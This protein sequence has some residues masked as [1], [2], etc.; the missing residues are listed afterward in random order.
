MNL[1]EHFF[2]L[3]KEMVPP[4]PDDYKRFK[5]F[6]QKLNVFLFENKSAYYMKD[7]YKKQVILS[8][9]LLRIFG[10]SAETPLCEK[11]AEMEKLIPRYEL[12]LLF[13]LHTKWFEFISALTADECLNS[14]F[15]YEFMIERKQG[16][17]VVINH[18]LRPLFL[19]SGGDIWFVLGK[20]RLSV[21]E[22]SESAVISFRDKTTRYEYSVAA[23]KFK[24]SE[25]KP[26][27]SREEEVLG[28]THAGYS[29]LQIATL[30]NIEPSTVK[31][32][33]K[34]IHRKLRPDE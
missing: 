1:F 19:T 10:F 28:L 33:K 29:A 13:E 32:H 20:L 23:K 27:S 18:Q 30:L 26:L 8:D 16:V 34:N 22:K 6:E 9:T 4:T 11:L 21:N 15:T 7:Y 3:A 12:P 5:D 17:T 25:T 24:L 31:F 2:D 14:V